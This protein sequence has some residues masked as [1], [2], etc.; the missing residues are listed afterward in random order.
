[1]YIYNNYLL[2][3]VLLQFQYC[4]LL[5]F[6]PNDKGAQSGHT[7]QAPLEWSYVARAPRVVKRLQ[8]SICLAD[9]SRT[10]FRISWLIKYTVYVGKCGISINV[11]KANAKQ[12][13]PQDPVHECVTQ[14]AKV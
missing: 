1:M 5:Y 11:K 12:A 10:L 8:R 13:N 6:L 4:L 9:D 3:L 2:F 14:K 7:Y